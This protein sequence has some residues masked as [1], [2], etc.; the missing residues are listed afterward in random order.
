M[1][2]ELSDGDG[3]TLD[4]QATIEELLQ[5]HG[6]A[7]ANGV[8]IPADE[9]RNEAEASEMKYMVT[10]ELLGEPIVRYFQSLVGSLLWCWRCT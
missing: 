6:L 3:Q 5:K 7:E 2:A 9:D 1:R 4:Q 10:E 8:Q